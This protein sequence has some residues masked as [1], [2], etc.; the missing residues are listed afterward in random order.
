MLSHIADSAEVVRS[1]YTCTTSSGCVG[2]WATCKEIFS[3]SCTLVT[4][5][6]ALLSCWK[7]VLG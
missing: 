6:G 4:R 3:L 7:P 1:I 2:S 5:S